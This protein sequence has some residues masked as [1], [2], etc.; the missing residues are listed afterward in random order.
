MHS[1]SNLDL[2]SAESNSKGTE[3]LVKNWDVTAVSHTPPQIPWESHLSPNNPRDSTGTPSGVPID[4]KCNGTLYSV[5]VFCG[6]SDHIWQYCQICKCYISSETV[7]RC[8]F[9]GYAHCVIGVTIYGNTNKY[10][11][12]IYHL[13]PFFDVNSM[14]MSIVWLEWL[15]QQICKCYISFGTI[16]Q[17][18]FNSDVCFVIRVTTYG[19]WD[20]EVSQNIV[21]AKIQDSIQY[22]SC[23]TTCIS[24]R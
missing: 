8:E 9:I 22:S 4:S 18:E 2:D 15:Y 7:F 1:F 5:H 23:S 10:T 11:S 6:R 16:F 21:K 12:V 24:V 20:E 17:Y 19:N 14:V 3:G 13:E